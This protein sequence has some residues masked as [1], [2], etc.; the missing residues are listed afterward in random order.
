MGP[1]LRAYVE[2]QLLIDLAHYGVSPT[3]LSFDWSNPCQEGHV[4]QYLDGILEE[5]SD[6]TVNRSDGTPTAEGWLDFIQGGADAPLFVFWLFLSLHEGDTWRKVKG[7]STIPHHI[8]E[9]LPDYSKDRCADDARWSRD[10]L[11]VAWRGIRR[12]S[13][14]HPIL[15]AGGSVEPK[16]GLQYVSGMTEETVRALERRGWRVF[17]LPPDVRD[18]AAFFAAIR[19]RLPLDPPLHSDRNWDAVADSLSGGLHLLPENK[20]A[21]IWPN[22]GELRSNDSDAFD[23]ATAVLA[24]TAQVLANSDAT[25]GNTKRVA[26]LLA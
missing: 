5:M 15:M 20:V 26:I 24:D 10:P 2:Q 21:I 14:Q 6:V 22:P 12:G 25:L 17:V 16:Q 1:Q 19:V 9:R 11:V 8:W 23:L 3:G 7:E 18:R 13:L 4:T